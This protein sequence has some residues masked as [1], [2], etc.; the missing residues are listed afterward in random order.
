MDEQERRIIIGLII[1]GGA[2]LYFWDENR[3]TSWLIIVVVAAAVVAYLGYRLIVRQKRLAAIALLQDLRTKGTQIKFVGG[4]I[5]N[6]AFDKGEDL[7]CALPRTT[8]LEPRAV[9][10]WRGE[11]SG[12]SFRITRGIWYRF[13]SS[14]GTSESHEEL[15]AVDIGTLAL[16]NQRLIFVGMAR[17]TSV[18]VEKIV[19]IEPMSDGIRLHREGKEKAQYFQLSSGLEATFQ[20]AGKTVSAPV[21]GDLIKAAID[22]AIHRRIPQAVGRFVEPS[23]GAQH[24]REAQKGTIQELV[25]PSRESPPSEAPRSDEDN[26]ETDW[27]LGSPG[28]IQVQV[29]ANI[30]YRDGR[31]RET[32]RDIRTRTMCPMTL[33]FLHFARMSK[34]IA[35]FWSHASSASSIS[36]PASLSRT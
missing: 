1:A 6:V 15:R 28:E 23:A 36:R 19:S 31:G 14:R 9:R 4:P 13:G 33:R 18:D 22:Q 32:R 2:V 8:L 3:S 10:T 24:A 17:T 25:Q 34:P 20:S 11:H 35:R 7:L 26:W 5:P 27:L 12:P 21:S 16:T 29:E 30:R